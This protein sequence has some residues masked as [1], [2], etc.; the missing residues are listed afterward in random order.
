MTLSLANDYTDKRTI[1]LGAEQALPEKDGKTLSMTKCYIENIS[2]NKDKLQAI[3]KIMAADSYFA[4]KPF[5]DKM[6]ELAFCLVSRLQSNC[7]LKYYPTD[8]WLAE[9]GVKRGKKPKYADNVDIANPDEQFLESAQI[10][11]TKRARIGIVYF[12]GLKRIVRILIVEWQKT[13]TVK[14]FNTDIDMVATEINR[15]TP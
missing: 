8:R 3:S 11:G 6:I 5:T 14:F 2:K 7:V 15:Y 10:D 9:R 12:N 4:R 13:G 1:M